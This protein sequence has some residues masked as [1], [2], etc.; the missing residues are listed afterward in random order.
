MMTDQPGRVTPAE[1]SE[2]LGQAL[3]LPRFP[4][5]ADRIALHE[6]KAAAAHPHRRRP[7]YPRSP[8]GRRRGLGPV[9]RPGRGA[10]GPRWTEGRPMSLSPFSGEQIVQVANPDPFAKPVLRAPVL[11]TPIW[12]IATAQPSGCCGGCSGSSPG[13]RSLTCSPPCSSWRGGGSAGPARSSSWP[14]SP[15]R[16]LTWRLALA[17]LLDP[18][19]RGPGLVPGCGAGRYRGQ[20]PAVMTI[21]RLAVALPGPAAPARPRLRH[22]APATPTGCMSGW[23]PASPPTTSPPLP[24]N[25][26]HGFGALACRIRTST[27]R[28]GPGRAG[29]P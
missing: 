28:R 8:R 20:W 21:S 17:R 11:H 26:A 5:L 1:I 22:L 12:M 6:R 27:A 14:S 3:A 15:R 18:A 29:P 23:C 25:L 19:R 24:A 4:S 16:P 2:F 7:R 13:I 10:A 9:S